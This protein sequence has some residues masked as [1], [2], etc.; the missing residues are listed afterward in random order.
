MNSRDWKKDLG[1]KGGQI[2]FSLC[3]YVWMYLQ[4]CRIVI[5]IIIIK[6]FFCLVACFWM[7]YRHQHQCSSL[8]EF[9]VLLDIGS[10]NV[11]GSLFVQTG[12]L[13]V[14]K[15]LST[16]WGYPR[17]EHLFTSN[18][19]TNYEIYNSQFWQILVQLMCWTT[20][21][22][23]LTYRIVPYLFHYLFQQDT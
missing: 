3:N 10:I 15:A 17:Y 16:Y 6:L 12:F 11:H 2:R 5:M 9:V 13:G 23:V 21:W 8:L 14:F 7:D 19:T 1:E 20:L 22:Y 18:K 4:L